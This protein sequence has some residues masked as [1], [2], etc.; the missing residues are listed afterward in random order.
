MIS[1]THTE[2][3]DYVRVT[4]VG[5]PDGTTNLEELPVMQVGSSK[6][7]IVGGN[8]P[9]WLKRAVADRY[10]NARAVAIKQEERAIVTMTNSDDIA[11]GS[12]I[13][14]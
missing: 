11:E 3:P 2:Y 7:V 5:N 12:T 4:V 1:L 13:Y 8:V 10:R 9:E 14:V 6:V